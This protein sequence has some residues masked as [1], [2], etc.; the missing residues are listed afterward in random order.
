MFR[1]TIFDELSWWVY[2]MWKT[3]LTDLGMN[4]SLQIMYTHTCWLLV[5][6][7]DDGIF[8]QD[9]LTIQ[10][11]SAKKDSHCLKEQDTIILPWFPN[12]PD[13]NSTYRCSWSVDVPQA[14][15]RTLLSHSQSYSVAISAAHNGYSGY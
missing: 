8:Q 10:N 5:C 15:F 2:R 14:P 9:N 11:Y 1:H 6:P 7:V 12:F 3:L 13:L 4:P